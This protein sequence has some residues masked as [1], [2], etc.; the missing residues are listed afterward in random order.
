MNL[1][2]HTLTDV[3]F[4]KEIYRKAIENYITETVQRLIEIAENVQQLIEMTNKEIQK[5]PT[6][7]DDDTNAMKRIVEE[8][9]KRILEYIGE[10]ECNV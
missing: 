4:A 8:L 5:V 7:I 6:Y 10:L 9:N 1:Q 2:L 3:R